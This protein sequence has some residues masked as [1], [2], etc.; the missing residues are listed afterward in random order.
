MKP[1]IAI[2]E[3]GFIS[4]RIFINVYKTQCFRYFAGFEFS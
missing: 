2:R 4:T 1:G 3:A